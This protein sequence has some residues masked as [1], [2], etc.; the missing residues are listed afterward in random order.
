MLTKIV[1]LSLESGYFAK[2]WKS[3]L[4]HPLLKKHGLELNNKTLR[5]MSNLQFTSKLAEKAAASQILRHMMD[6]DLLANLL[7]A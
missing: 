1:N 4:V 3:A 2:E 6:N 7:S 5:P